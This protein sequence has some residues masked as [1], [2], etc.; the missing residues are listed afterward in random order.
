MRHVFCGEKSK[1]ADSRLALSRCARKAWEEEG[2]LL[3]MGSGTD[4]Q[5]SDRAQFGSATGA[6]RSLH[7][8]SSCLAHLREWGR[9]ANATPDHKSVPRK[10]KGW[11]HFCAKVQ[12]VGKTLFG[13]LGTSSIH[14]NHICVIRHE[15]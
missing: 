14:R 4:S 2:G 12:P 7:S 9:Q 8:A 15:Q 1:E 10:V 5:G 3:R 13:S 6:P 11:P